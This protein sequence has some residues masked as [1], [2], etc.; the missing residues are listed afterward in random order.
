MKKLVAYFSATGTTQTLA[1]NLAKG[2]MFI[3]WAKSR[4]FLWNIDLKR[5]CHFKNKFGIFLKILIWQNVLLWRHCLLSCKANGETKNV[6]PSSWCKPN[7]HNCSMPQS[8]WQNRQT[9]MLWWGSRNKKQLL[10]LE[11]TEKEKFNFLSFE[12][13]K[14]ICC[15]L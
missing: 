2:L 15:V 10:L 6:C 1:E 8:C 12:K 14:K 11:K 13:T 7:L 3:F 4:I 5:E 9:D